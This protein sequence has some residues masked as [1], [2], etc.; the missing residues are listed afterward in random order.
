M[1]TT[2][3]EWLAFPLASVQEREKSRQLLAHK[4]GRKQDIDGHH[5]DNDVLQPSLVMDVSVLYVYVCT[6]E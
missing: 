5:V 1:A 2:R 3:I 4:R 6:L